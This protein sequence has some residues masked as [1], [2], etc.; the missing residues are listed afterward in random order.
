MAAAGINA[1]A[2]RLNDRGAMAFK[3]FAGADILNEI[4]DAWRRPPLEST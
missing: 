1:P 4:A 3:N 2:A